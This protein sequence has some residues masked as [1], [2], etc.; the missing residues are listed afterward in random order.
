MIVY[1]SA[2]KAARVRGCVL[3]PDVPEHPGVSVLPDGIAD[4]A[5]KC[6]KHLFLLPS[7]PP[8]LKPPL[9]Q[10]VVDVGVLKVEFQ[11]LS[12]DVCLM[13]HGVDVNHRPVGNPKR[14]V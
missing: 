1:S 11:F 4:C 5:H 10:G 6:F 3:S 2:T 14:K 7:Q 8:T 12:T 13:R 9:L